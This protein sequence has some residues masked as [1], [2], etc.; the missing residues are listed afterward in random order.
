MITLLRSAALLIKRRLSLLSIILSFFLLLYI[1]ANSQNQVY[2]LTHDATP[3]S[4]SSVDLPKINQTPPQ[5][6]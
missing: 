4:V 1:T 6:I 3:G 2:Y 5:L